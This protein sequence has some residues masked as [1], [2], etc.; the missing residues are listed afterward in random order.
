MTEQAAG[1]RVVIITALSLECL[2]VCRHLKDRRHETHPSGTVYERG[3]FEGENGRAWDILVVEAGAGNTGAA[4]E[5]E[6]SI[7]FFQPEIAFFVGV[8]GGL[9]DVRVGDVVIANKV[10][11]YESGKDKEQFES[12]PEIHMPSYR[13]AQRAR[14]EIRD[15]SWAE[16]INGH[17]LEHLPGA[18]FGPIAAGEKVIA[19]TS[20]ATH[21]FVK[22]RYSDA[23]AVEME[24]YGFLRGIYMNHGVEALVIRGI[25][26]LIDDKPAADARGSQERAADAASA[27]A[28][29]LLAHLDQCH[30]N[31]AGGLSSVK[32]SQTALRSEPRIDSRSRDEFSERTKKSVAAR[33][34]WRCSF[35]G[36]GKPTVGPSEE[37]PNAVT[38]IGKA[39]HICGTA[40]GRGS[41]RYDPSMTPEERSDI[42]NAIWLCP[43]HADLIDRDEVTY[44][45]RTLLAMK[46]EHEA[47]CAQGVRLGKSFDLSAGLLAI[48]PDIICTGDVGNITAVSWTLHLKHFV[49][50]DVHRLASFIDGFAKAAPTDAYVLSNELGDGRVLSGAPSLTKQNDGY[51]LFCP[52]AP[53]FPRIDAHALGIDYARRSETGDP[54][55][56]GE[57]SF[58]LVSGQEALQHKIQSMLSMQQGESPF[59]PSFGIRFFE[60]FEAFSGSPWLSLLLKLEVVRQ[61]AIPY[62]D[63]VLKLQYTPFQCVTHVYSFELLSETPENNRLPVRVDFDVQGVGRWQRDLLIYMPTREQMDEQAERQAAISALFSQ[64]RR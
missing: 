32:P 28:F 13:L 1:G 23:L 54:S 12:R 10:Y 15:L 27:F 9:K 22:D 17:A 39:A 48:G 5:A 47:S 3:L 18:F 44:S 14:A 49:L 41:R 63:N 46:R 16:R 62:T 25:S 61:A 4:A 40:A 55:G 37:S 24:G 58:A 20:S 51:S 31:T 21:R 8:A 59:H 50:G 45:V 42:D 57:K 6:R 36:C 34:S 43:D 33:A 26:D 29:E 38:M 53:R 60:Y 2:A 19:S 11:S 35:T 52:V 30:T 7:S 56:A 64:V